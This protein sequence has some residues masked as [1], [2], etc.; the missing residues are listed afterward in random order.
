MKKGLIGL[1]ALAALALVSCGGNTPNPQPGSTT[2]VVSTDETEP[3]ISGN[4]DITCSV[5]DTV[6]LLKD[7]KAVDDTDGDISSKVSVS[8]MPEITITNGKVTPTEQ[9]EYEVKYSV[10]DAAGNEAEAFCT[11]TVNPKLAEKVLYKEFE[12]GSSTELPFT[13]FGFTDEIK[14]AATVAKGN[15]ILSGKTDNEAWHIKFEN[16]I[17]TKANAE[18][19]VIFEFS[20]NVAGN[21]TFEAYDINANK[22]VAIQEGFN[23]LSFKFTA[24]Q[25]KEDQGFCLQ[26]GALP[27]DYELGFSHIEIKESVGQDVWGN[28]LKNFK[29]NG[30][31]VVTSAFD[32]N[33]TGNVTTEED[34]AVMNITRGSDENGVWQTKLFVKAGL[35]LEKDAKYRISVDVEAQKAINQ[36]EICY[37]SGDEE[38]GIGALY[39]QKVEAGVKK[40]IEFIV[41]PSAAKDNLVLLFQLGKQNTAKDSN[42][43]TVSNLKVEKAITEDVDVL[44]N[45]TFATDKVGSHF[46][47]GSVGTF[48]AATDGSKAVMDVTHGVDN[49]NVWELYAE[50]NLD[51]ALEAGNTYRV[52]LNMKSTALIDG[53]EL[54]PRKF[55]SE[56]A[57]GEGGLWGQKIEANETKTL[58]FDVKVSED[59]TNPALAFQLGKLTTAAN[60][61]FSNVKVVIPG[62]VKETS[63]LDSYEFTPDAFGTYNEAPLGEGFLYEKDGKLVYE[64]TKI[65]LTDWHNKMYISKIRLE[66]NKIYT[67]E[68]EA[69]ADKAISCAFFVNPCGKWDPRVSEQMDFTTEVKTFSFVTPKFAADM[70][71]EVLFQFGSEANHA[72]GGAK[73][74][75]SS[76]KVYS[77]DVA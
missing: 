65:A 58:T 18:Y 47:A 48:T 3:T 34:K 61:E 68:I 11:L 45:Y 44:T 72:L 10:K 56:N 9:G 37:N 22:T 42:V 23:K 40:T 50:I 27:T 29:F 4:K 51:T 64:M 43:V 52:S 73:I 46:W 7:I 49:P 31:N 71:F 41:T 69:K 54:L 35:D 63:T 67:F 25:A 66:A 19:E 53:F 33:S 21:V 15:Y 1:S 75:F 39:D 62:G 26:L 74:E 38:K 55:G 36:F 24:S 17:A 70:D 6:D 77:Q 16:K 8:I 14:P 28:L 57:F 5:E 76:I 20:S 60:I 13:T 12:F 59:V 32:N 2:T 30:A